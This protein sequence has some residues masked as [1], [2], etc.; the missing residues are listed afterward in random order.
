MSQLSHQSE[1]R[2]N[3]CAARRDARIEDNIDKLQEAADKDPDP[4]VNAQLQYWTTLRNN[5]H[6]NAAIARASDWVGTL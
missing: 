1:G 5:I 4:Q 3:R 2:V 6:K